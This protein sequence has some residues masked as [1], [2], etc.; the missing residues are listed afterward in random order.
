MIQSIIYEFRDQHK[1]ASYDNKILDNDTRNI[2]NEV[3]KFNKDSEDLM[4]LLDK[5]SD[6]IEK[7]WIPFN[8]LLKSPDN[9]SYSE[10]EKHFKVVLSGGAG[11][12]V[13][14]MIEIEKIAIKTYD[15]LY[16]MDRLIEDTESHFCGNYP[17]LRQ[18]HVIQF[19]DVVSNKAFKAYNFIISADKFM[20]RRGKVSSFYETYLLVNRAR[21]SLQYSVEFARHIIHHVSRN[22]RSCNR[23]ADIKD[24]TYVEL[25]GPSQGFIFDSLA[26]L[27]GISCK[28]F[29]GKYDHC[30]PNDPLCLSHTCSADGGV[31]K[32]C[33]QIS[34]KS[35]ALCLSE[36]PSKRYLSAV[37][38]LKIYGNQSA[39]KHC[40]LNYMRRQKK[41]KMVRPVGLSEL[42]LIPN[43]FCYCNCER[44]KWKQ[45]DVRSISFN[46]ALADTESNRV[47]TNL[48]FEE[49]NGMISLVPQTGVLLPGGLIDQKTVEW[50]RTYS[51]E[52]VFKNDN[53]VAYYHRFQEGKESSTSYMEVDHDFMYISSGLSINLDDITVPRSHVIVGVR[54]NKAE[55]RGNVNDKGIELSVKSMQFDPNSGELSRTRKLHIGAT[56]FMLNQFQHAKRQV[57]NLGDPNTPISK[58]SKNTDISVPYQR[59]EFR[60]TNKNDD[61]GQSFVPFIDI[62]GAKTNVAMPLSTISLYHRGCAE[63]GGFI[64]LKF[65]S[66]DIADYFERVI[67]NNLSRYI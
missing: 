6:R 31:L 65:Q 23:D 35:M 43:E 56:D 46:W 37:S 49:K 5:I 27:Q 57:I 12:L 59:V 44:K 39:A 55:S 41:W 7:S 24:K 17:I 32:N 28:A 52:P 2:F 34:K 9:V 50:T 63:S 26:V 15:T 36:D 60:Q 16:S 11:S 22:I 67:N 64:A 21:F 45:G 48:R 38:D 33:E 4:D 20:E 51:P 3:Y 61:L 62:R 40:P 29:N 25:T 66:L 8:E 54:L 10:L 1:W 47:I 19:F 18:Q 14:S 30:K 42:N 58:P 13:E 53:L